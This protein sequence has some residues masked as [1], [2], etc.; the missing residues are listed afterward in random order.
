AAALSWSISVLH[1][2]GHAWSLSPLQVTP[3]QLLLA[4]AVV[5]PIALLFDGDVRPRWSPTLLGVLAYNGPIATA[6]A[7][8]AATSISRPRPAVTSSLS[9]LAVPAMGIAVSAAAL[10]EVPDASLLGGFALILGGVGLVSLSDLR[11]AA[12]G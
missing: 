8:W 12:P 2:R 6:F 5:T 11:A 7:F 1:I 9:F 3:W 4:A 10:G